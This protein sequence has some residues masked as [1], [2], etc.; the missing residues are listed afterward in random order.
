MTWANWPNI[1]VWSACSLS[2]VLLCLAFIQKHH[3]IRLIYFKRIK[4][5]IYICISSQQITRNIHLSD[6]KTKKQGRTRQTTQWKDTGKKTAH[7]F[8]EHVHYF[9]QKFIIGI[10]LLIFIA[11]SKDAV[12]TKKAQT[13][14]VVHVFWNEA[15]QFWLSG[16][17]L[18]KI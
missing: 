4:Q 3:W 5:Q 15:V 1:L 13:M 7:R 16:K 2:T 17:I 12:T 9:R 11:F 6:E 18:I 10:N 14:H 8:F